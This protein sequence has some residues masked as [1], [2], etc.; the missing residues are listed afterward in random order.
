MS[1]RRD[2]SQRQAHMTPT[3]SKNRS[4]P[5]LLSGGNPQIPKGEG[6]GPVQDYIAAMPGWK[7]KVGKHLDGLIVRTLPG[8]H[9]AVKWN[10]PF[11]GRDGEGWFLSFRCYAKYVQ[12]AFFRGT[13]LDPPPPKGSKHP[14]VRYLDIREG[15]DIDEQQLVSWIEQAGRLPGE[16]M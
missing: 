11:Y 3:R 15:D 5:R 6:D 14:E 8:V 12:V 7:R 9:K 13:S 1:G 2:S 16:T 4:Q 10:Q